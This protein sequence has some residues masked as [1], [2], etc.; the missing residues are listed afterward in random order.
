[1]TTVNDRLEEAGRQLAAHF[2]KTD[3]CASRAQSFFIR[4]I[5]EARKDLLG[6]LLAWQP[7]PRGVEDAQIVRVDACMIRLLQR[8]N[9]QKNSECTAIFIAVER[10]KHG[11]HAD[12]IAIKCI[13]L[14]QAG[15]SARDLIGLKD[16]L[17][18]QLV[19][20]PRIIAYSL[21]FWCC[22]K[23]H[24]IGRASR[25]STSA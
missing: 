23:C 11:R 12:D 5:W 18:L 17:D 25:E 15:R 10:A 24:R 4:Q 20:G 3:I 13:D 7:K 19:R 21:T 9:P 6:E 8:G 1:M 2:Q 16:P 22:R 14:P